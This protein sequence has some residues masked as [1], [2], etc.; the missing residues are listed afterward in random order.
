M[1]SPDLANYR[2]KANH[3]CGTIQG[4]SGSELRMERTSARLR[5]TAIYSAGFVL[6]IASGAALIIFGALVLTNL[7]ALDFTMGV[8]SVLV[9][10]AL[11]V[12]LLAALLLIVDASSDKV[13][14]PSILKPR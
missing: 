8:F 10:A 1:V 13:W 9:I 3:N 6:L 4:Q 14:P 5:S 2:F 12:L 7:S 11:S